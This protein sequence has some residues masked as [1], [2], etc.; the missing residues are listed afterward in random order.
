MFV[1]R[2]GQWIEAVITG[3]LT[4]I[5]L[6]Q[7][8]AVRGCFEALHV[9]DGVEGIRFCHFEDVMWFDIL[10]CSGLCAAYDSYGRAQPDAAGTGRCG[11][12]DAVEQGTG[13][14]EQGT[15]KNE[16]SVEQVRGNSG[17]HLVFLSAGISSRGAFLAKRE[18]RTLWQGTS[19]NPFQ[20]PFAKP[21][22]KGESS[23]LSKF[24]GDLG[25]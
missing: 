6:P 1:T 22:G 25:T 12:G 3:D 11:A 10:W 23:P 2:H 7:S 16:T 17:M 15:G 5:D 13:N 18:S 4:Q 24:C 19:G 21:P 8:E 14:R 9:L 20:S